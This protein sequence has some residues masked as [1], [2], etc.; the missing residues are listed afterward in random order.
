M[1]LV[2]GLRTSAHFAECSEI[3]ECSKGLEYSKI[4]EYSKIIEYCKMMGCYQMT[5]F[6]IQDIIDHLTTMNFQLGCC[7]YNPEHPK[8]AEIMKAEGRI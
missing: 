6:D 4:C 2:V 8:F 5:A 7:K 3:L 1:S